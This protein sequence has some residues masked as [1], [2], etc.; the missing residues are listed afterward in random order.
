MAEI[1]LDKIR[2]KNRMNTEEGWSTENPTL[3]DGEIGYISN[4]KYTGLYKVGDGKTPWNNLKYSFAEQLYMDIKPISSN[5][6]V[7]MEYTNSVLL[8]SGA[9]TVTIPF[10]S[11]GVHFI[12]KNISAD[13]VTITPQGNTIDGSSESITLNQY[14]YIKL[15]Q[16][17][18]NTYIV[19]DNKSNGSSVDLSS[20]VLGDLTIDNNVY[21]PDT[22]TQG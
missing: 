6:S 20:V 2:I 21:T 11:N 9:Y 13:V 10:I 7:T 3:L 5:V 17:E 15:L 8:V 12:I 19:E 4:G 1:T 14:E 18:N 16:Y 22:V